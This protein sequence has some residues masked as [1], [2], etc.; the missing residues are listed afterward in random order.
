[1]HPKDEMVVWTFRFLRWFCPTHLYE[2]IEGDLIQRFNRD[3]KNGGERKAKKKL[4]WNAILFC[5]ADILLRNKF[6]F[7]LNYT[8]MLRSYI[9]VACRYFIKRKA[10]SLI[11]MLGLSIGFAVC[12]VILKHVD[13]ELS[14]DR[15]HDKAGRIYRTVSTYHT[16]GELKGTY[17]LSDFGQGPSLL[18]NIPDVKNYVRTHF[19]HGGAVLST[20]ADSGERIQFYEDESIQFVDSTFFDVFTHDAV[21]GD[22]TTALDAPN[23]IVLTEHAAHKYFGTNKDILGRV[24][25]VSGNWWVNQDYVVT[26]VI[27]NVPDNSHFTFDFLLSMHNLLLNDFYRSG[28]GTSIEGNFVTYVELA[29]GSDVET[30][31]EKLNDFINRFQ[32]A[33]LERLNTKGVLTL[34]PIEDIHL[35]P[36]LDLEFSPT[37]SLHTIYFFI[38]I[39]LLI[40]GV[41]WINYI[42]LSTA[43]ATDRGKEVGIKKTIGAGRGQLIL[44][45]LTESILMHIASAIVAV[46]LTIFILPHIGKILYEDLRLDMTDY[47]L[48]IIVSGFILIG[49]FV[50][51]IYPALVMSSFRPLVGLKGIKGSPKKTFSLR[52]ALVVFQFAT[53]LLII[54]GTFTVM[55]Q[56]R[57]MKE[58][59]KGY[60]SEQTLVIKGPGIFDSEKSQNTLISLKH[61][62]K[63]ISSVESV[64][65]SEAIPGGGYNWGTGMRKSGSQE[66]NRNGEVVFVDADFVN[67]YNLN[68]VSGNAWNLETPSTGKSI[69]LN[70]A[71]VES[72]GFADSENATGG[73][74]IIGGDTF[75]I[76]GVLKNYHWSSLKKSITPFVLIHNKACAKYISIK[77]KGSNVT[78]SIKQIET[79]FKASLPEIPFDY[80][81]LED[82]FNRQY[83]DDQQFGK[84]FNLFALITVI[85][86][87]LG[88]SALA[89]LNTSR[90]LKEVSIRKVLGAS[91]FSLT[92]LLTLRFFKLLL[93]ACLIAFP[94]SWYGVSTWLSRYAYRI[95]VSWDLLIAPIAVLT[96]IATVIVSLQT[97]KGALTNPINNLR[98]E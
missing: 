85:L 70:E 14:F 73:K 47:R 38:L 52:D 33:E 16:N 76:Q 80:Y 69:L 86:A 40:I 6:S 30:V 94:F 90:R 26:A 68:L 50:A 71:G 3:I 35:S 5:R 4:I 72:F 64:T 53:S 2:E 31:K 22:L 36:G 67:A 58:Q 87:C 54:T 37:V 74:L 61:A 98:A 41:A 59:D 95:E 51:S 29:P 44:Q 10:F 48:W 81:F 79:Q 65:S 1:M 62:L 25:K 55:R 75:E 21:D 88:L 13:F 15:Y 27:K 19:L 63:E 92:S 78:E 49:S 45:F 91:V 57:F 18:D 39:A 17:P 28:S 66:G 82:F 24:I 32:G 93:I 46:L 43:R 7:D 83:G 42:N 9:K 8:A 84:I 56:L 12:L 34:Q 97:I 60:A 11:N 77:L 20:T 96:T 89:S 23:S